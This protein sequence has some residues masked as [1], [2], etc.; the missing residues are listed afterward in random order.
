MLI[1]HNELSCL[2]QQIL[3][4][5]AEQLTCVGL[6]SGEY[7][8]PHTDWY[9]AELQ[10]I[11]ACFV[12]LQSGQ[13][14]LGTIGTT[15]PQHPLVIDVARNSYEVATL[16]V[17]QLGSPKSD[18]SN[19]QLDVAVLSALHFISEPTFE[20]VANQIQTGSNGVF[21]RCHDCTATFLPT[22]RERFGDSTNFLHQL[23]VRA[24]IETDTWPSGMQ[25]ATF[26]TQHFSRDIDKH[27]HHPLPR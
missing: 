26:T 13:R 9:P 23:C 19:L 11:Q 24:G 15:E 18:L 4:D 10:N 14:V 5:V 8:D 22:M 20:G 25:V 12:S 3:L 6:A 16:V 17:H 27:Q 1:K 7:C 2:Q 21:V